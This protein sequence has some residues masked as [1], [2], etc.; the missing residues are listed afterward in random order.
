MTEYSDF[1]KRFNKIA[2]EGNMVVGK[3]ATVLKF[4][5]EL[6]PKD[7]LVEVNAHVGRM[8]QGQSVYTDDNI[9]S[10]KCYPGYQFPTKSKKWQH[11]CIVTNE[12][13]MLWV[14][15]NHFCFETI[16]CLKKPD[17]TEMTVL[18]ERA[19]AVYSIGQEF[20]SLVPLTPGEI[21]KLDCNCDD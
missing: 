13:F 2:G 6:A 11:R 9:A 17:L 21:E 18:S 10:K 20:L 8:P 14:K 15:R 7:A 5:F 19:A 4:L 3:R 1:T 12:S 16:P